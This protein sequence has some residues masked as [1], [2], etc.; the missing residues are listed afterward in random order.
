MAGAIRMK[1]LKVRAKMYLILV[2]VVI[3][4]AFTIIFS[5]MY[6]GEL[7]NAG[8]ELLTSDISTDAAVAELN[9]I[10]RK[11]IDVLLI[12]IIV[13]FFATV[14]VGFAISRS[15]T[16]AL[17]VLKSDI[18]WITQ[19]D[20]THK[21]TEKLLARN[22]D[23][24]M[25]AQ[26]IEQIRTDML[27][28]IGHVN[29]EAKQLDHIVREISE[30]INTLNFDVEEVSA[31]TEELAASME[32]TAASSD[33]IASMSAEIN[34]AAQ[35]MTEHADDGTKEVVQIH[36]RADNVRNETVSTRQRLNHIR[37]EIA[38]SLTQALKEAEIVNEISA[39]AESIMNITS[40]TNLLALNAS[41]EAARAGEAGKGF[42]VVADEIRNLA[43]QS[44]TTVT[45][46]QEVTQN[47]TVAVTNLTEDS[48]RLLNFVGTDISQ[49]FDDFEKMA[50]SYN[51][52][53]TYLD[54]LV[55]EFSSTS[56]NLLVSIE[57]VKDSVSGINIAA[58]EGASGITNI[59]NKMVNVTNETNDV[60]KA[61]N[62]AQT[63]SKN[64]F[65]N[66]AQFKVD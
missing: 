45:H 24:G 55:S 23:F 7:K 52:D 62:E 19:R 26:T 27:E 43:E 21:F 50:G 39:L 66:V 8:I 9:Q 42:A 30:N 16:T 56:S 5:R 15:F 29:A 41:I 54:T 38:E 34:T 11:S 40:Q 60:M 12:G 18:S 32:E 35:N 33:E 4:T 65:D 44:R 31:T 64:L 37:F 6:L 49:S 36:K 10:Y 14:A 57:H 2:C 17:D 61:I 51:D 48:E 47:V 25:L 3:L 13:I 1:N 22:D 20:F 28:L 59:A 63:V 53:A 46:I 58:E